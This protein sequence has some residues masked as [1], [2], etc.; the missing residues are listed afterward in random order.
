MQATHFVS[1]ASNEAYDTEGQSITGDFL[2]P[3][4][5]AIF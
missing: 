5:I 1:Y 2:L 4:F 3:L